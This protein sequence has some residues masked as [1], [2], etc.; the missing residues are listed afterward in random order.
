MKAAAQRMSGSRDIYDRES[1]GDT[2]SVNFITCHDGFTMWDLYSYNEKHN[3]DNGWDNTD[4]D[5]NNNSWNCGAEGWTDRQDVI[6]L[7][8][9]LVRNAF[10][11][12][13]T[14][15]GVP[16]MYAG[17]EFLNTQY[18]NNNAYCQD[19][20]ISWLNWD[21]LLENHK[22]SQFVKEMI[23]FRKKHPVLRSRGKNALCGLP[24]VSFHGEEPWKFKEDYENHLLG[25]LFAGREKD[26]DTDD[27]VYV[28]MNM[29][30]EPHT[31]RLPELPLD[32]FWEIF[33][34]TADE[35]KNGR[36]PGGEI[37][38]EERSIIIL[39]G[40]QMGRKGNVICL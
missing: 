9:K 7:R 6:R 33:S 8:K 1:R 12:L 23:R 22:I 40:N 30:W 31:V 38:L 16:M 36:L 3:L 37:R 35:P 4:G 21:L 19:N 32:Y 14:S 28:M 39:E 15:Q 34:D 26:S 24:S 29:H 17:D 27:I 11:A 2:A 5:N 13:M 25:V 18:G 10:A 20:E